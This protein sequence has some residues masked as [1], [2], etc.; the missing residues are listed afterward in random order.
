M[1]SLFFPSNFDH[2]GVS[3]LV[4]SI[5]YVFLYHKTQSKKMINE[6]IQIRKRKN[7]RLFKDLEMIQM[8]VLLAVTAEEKDQKV[9]RQRMVE[10]AKTN[11]YSMANLCRK[12]L[13]NAIATG[14]ARA[15]NYL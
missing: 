1:D 6:K 8:E 12:I 14:N 7:D 11:K 10:L 3:G 13:A 9:R 15:E 4:V 5:L 2:G